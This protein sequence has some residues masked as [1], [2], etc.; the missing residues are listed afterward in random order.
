MGGWTAANVDRPKRRREDVG[1]ED[2]DAGYDGDA[3]DQNRSTADCAK[4][5]RRS[6]ETIEAGLARLSSSYNAAMGSVGTLHRISMNM[7]RESAGSARGSSNGSDACRAVKDDAGSTS[8]LDQMCGVANAARDA[9]ASIIQDPLVRPYVPTWLEIA[10]D[11]VRYGGL[12]RGAEEERQISSANHRST[13][14]ELT[15]LVL[16]NYGDL[17]MCGCGYQSFPSAIQ[18]KLTLLDRGTVR[19]LEGLQL[20]RQ[21]SSRALSHGCWE[22]ESDEDDESPGLSLDFF[23][24]FFFLSLAFWRWWR[25]FNFAASG[26]IS[27][28]AMHDALG[29]MVP[30]CCQSTMSRRASFS[31]LTAS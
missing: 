14:K 10:E 24:F 4:R 27:S 11:S 18:S 22:G 15:Y 31:T 19:I 1:G 21:Y 7:V 23:P 26:C 5:R 29:E 13:V 9:L 6:A 16:V 3:D 25:A 17:L 20:T 12:S 30:F 8:R 28:S 2:E